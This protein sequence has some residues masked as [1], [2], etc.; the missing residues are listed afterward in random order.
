[1]NR[2]EHLLTCLAEECAEVGQRVSKALRFGLREVQPGQPLTNADRILDELRDLFAVAEICA[3][4]GLIGWA[5]P[6]HM[7]VVAKG[8]KIERFMKIG[9]AQGVLDTE[10]LDA[11]EARISMALVA[12]RQVLDNP[13]DAIPLTKA[14]LD[15]LERSAAERAEMRGEA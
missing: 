5:M 4:E 7:E 9:V 2:A 3:G 15:I 13:A 14:A 11:P 8:A 1:M 12:L 10:D 6:D